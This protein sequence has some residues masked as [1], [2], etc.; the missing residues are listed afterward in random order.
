[1]EAIIFIGQNHLVVADAD[2]A[3][4]QRTIGARI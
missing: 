4:L 3:V 2:P 1:M